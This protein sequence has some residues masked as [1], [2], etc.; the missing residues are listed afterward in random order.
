VEITEAD[1]ETNY[2]LYSA[3][4]SIYRLATADNE[5]RVGRGEEWLNDF[6]ECGF[7]VWGEFWEVESVECY[8]RKYGI[9]KEYG[10]THHATVTE[11]SGEYTLIL[12]AAESFGS[13]A[14]TV[15]DILDELKRKPKDSFRGVAEGRAEY[16]SERYSTIPSH[17]E[18]SSKI[19]RSL[20]D[21]IVIEESGNVIKD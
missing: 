11:E 21:S 6:G 12:L 10:L 20:I 7:V 17:I 13:I 1:I 8:T 19:W 4:E 5:A 3:L 9:V 15:K 14:A 2:E 16:I 18:K